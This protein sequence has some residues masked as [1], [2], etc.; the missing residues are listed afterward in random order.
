MARLVEDVAALV[1]AIMDHPHAPVFLYDIAAGITIW[2]AHN[3]IQS[4]YNS[5]TIDI[6]F[7]KRVLNFVH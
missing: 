3:E 4:T 2:A 7:K 6:T 5:R 1:A